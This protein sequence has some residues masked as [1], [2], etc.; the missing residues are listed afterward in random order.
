M[1]DFIKNNKLRV[2][3][4][5][6]M[7][8]LFH[9]IN[10]YYIL[11]KS[12]YCLGPDSVNYLQRTDMIAKVIGKMKLNLNSIK[13]SYAQ[14]FADTYKPPFF[15]LAAS[16]FFTFSRDKNIATM[17]NM[18]FFAIL[19]FA[20]Y[21]IGNKLYGSQAGLLSAFLVSM[22]PG[23]FAVSRIFMVDF[24]LAAM[25][26]LAG[27]LLI[28]DRLGSM[29]F[30]LVTGITIGLCALVK[31]SYFIF[32]LPLLAYVFFQNFKNKKI[33]RNLILS[34][35]IGAL[36]AVSYYAAPRYNYYHFA[37]QI[38]NNSTPLYYLETI[39][40][41]QLLPVFFSLFL[42]SFFVLFKK[43]RYFWVI[44]IL[45]PV[46]LFSVSPNKQDRFILPVF[47]YIAVIISGFIWSLVKIRK[48]VIPILIFFSIFQYYLICYK[49][50]L[51]WNKPMISESGL[52]SMLDEGDWVKPGQEALALTNVDHKINR[53]IKVMFIGQEQEVHTS[54][55]Y[56][57]LTQRMPVEVSRPAIDS[58]FLYRPSYVNMDFNGAI[59]Q[60]DF[61]IIENSES[62]KW[63][64]I[65]YLLDAF[66]LRN[67]KFELVKTIKFPNDILYRVYKKRDFAS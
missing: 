1:A 12:R 15:F 21:G 44:A 29:L 24:A 62:Q 42:L 26:T 37:F 25:L 64:H 67:D 60:S 43:N 45:L 22:F 14:I 46:L 39:F 53:P 20:T 63:I 55:D 38:R 34:I 41:R 8:L 10:N 27:Y 17:S 5:L 6:F 30:S 31:Q 28:A 51:V 13:N 50:N 18:I 58:D 3:L 56:C 40:K 7:L 65:R 16:P 49:G 2:F 33:L 59:L 36:I 48:F 9:G 35:A 23:I 4:I 11:T 61:I 19:L 47:P 57:I 32:L 54:L 66:K 52:F